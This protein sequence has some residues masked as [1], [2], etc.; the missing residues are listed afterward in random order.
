VVQPNNAAAGRRGCIIP[1]VLGGTAGPD[2]VRWSTVRVRR[3]PYVPGRRKP[4]FVVEV[5][6]FDRLEGQ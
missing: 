1:G 3:V 2:V 4:W 5:D 6:A